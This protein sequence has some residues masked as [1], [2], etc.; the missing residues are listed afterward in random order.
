MIG[1]IARI[2]VEQGQTE[3]LRQAL[4]RAIKEHSI[5]SEALFLALQ[6]TGCRFFC[7]APRFRIDDLDYQRLGTAI[8]LPE[9]RRGSRLH[10]PSLDDR[11]LVSDLLLNAPAPSGTRSDAPDVVDARFR[12]TE[13]A[14]SNGPDDQNASG[15]TIHAD[16]RF[17][18]KEGS[19][20]VSS[21]PAWK[22]AKKNTTSSVSA[23]KFQRTPGNR[24]CPF[25]WGST[26]KLRVQSRQRDGDRPSDAT[27]KQNLNKCWHRARGSNFENADLTPGLLSA[28]Q[29]YPCVSTSS[30]EK[31]FEYIILGA[32]DS[33]PEQRIVSY[34]RPLLVRPSSGKNLA[35]WSSCLPKNE[36]P[37][38]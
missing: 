5:S 33:E 11:D 20:I 8:I 17:R 28:T 29:G 4:N 19:L 14:L 7:R 32:W 2:L 26:G 10:D 25:L 23:R 12:R 3:E 13:Q 36:Q 38:G 37:R 18:R 30:L 35:E 34:R 22:S 9:N 6:G 21:G 31:T 16:R 15:V 1:E 24:Y 27:Q